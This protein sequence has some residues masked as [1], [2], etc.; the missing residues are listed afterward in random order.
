MF[1]HSEHRFNADGTYTSKTAE[2]P[3]TSGTW[4]LEGDVLIR[5][6]DGKET[7]N[8]INRFFD[9]GFVIEYGKRNRAGY[10]RIDKKNTDDD[11]SKD[12]ADDAFDKDVK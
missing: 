4:K 2:A 12:E 6:I 9:Q 10:Y 3:Q 1:I 5:S 7:S 8:R 11:P